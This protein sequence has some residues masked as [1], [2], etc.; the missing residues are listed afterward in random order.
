MQS[1]SSITRS[2]SK[3]QARYLAYH[4]AR[5]L[6]GFLFLYSSISKFFR[7][8]N[9]ALIISDYQMFPD[10]IISIAAITLPMLELAVG[11]AL[12][13]NILPRGSSAILN[14]LLIMFLAVLGINILRGIDGNCGCFK[15]DLNFVGS[16]K[17]AFMRDIVLIS[18][19]AFVQYNAFRY[20]RQDNG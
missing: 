13:F 3:E 11:A 6:F 20:A 15:V 14:G 16:Y 17:F 5:V 12:M 18:I 9:F 19:G 8:D 1:I 10:F 2:L 4:T 7:P